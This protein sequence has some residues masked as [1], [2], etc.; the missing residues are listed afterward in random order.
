MLGVEEKARNNR[1]RPRDERHQRQGHVGIVDPPPAV[2]CRV[3]L[4]R[5]Q[6]AVQAPADDEDAA[7]GR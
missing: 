3:Q 5:E 4:A 2:T 7:D 6:E 1:H